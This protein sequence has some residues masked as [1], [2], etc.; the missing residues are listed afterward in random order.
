MISVSP[1][2]TEAGLRTVLAG[3]DGP[4]LLMLG[5]VTAVAPLTTIILARWRKWPIISFLPALMGSIILVAL[6]VAH[7]RHELLRPYFRVATVVAIPFE[8]L[9]V[10][11]ILFTALAT[12]KGLANSPIKNDAHERIHTAVL[13]AAG[14][15]RFSEILAGE[16]STLY[17]GLFSWFAR[18]SAATGQTAVAY[19]RSGGYG[20][21]LP[22]I[23]TLIALETTVFHLIIHGSA[24][25]AAWALTILGI[26]GIIWVIADDRATWLRPILIDQETLFVNSGLRWSG[27]VSL[28]NIR[29]VRCLQDGAGPSCGPEIR[30]LTLYGQPQLCVELKEPVTLERFLGFTATTSNIGISVDDWQSFRG[31]LQSAGVPVEGDLA[32]SPP[33]FYERLRD[34]LRGMLRRPAAADAL[35]RELAL[36]GCAFYFLGIPPSAPGAGG[37]AFTIHRRSNYGAIFVV[38]LGLALLEMTVVHLMLRHSSPIT[39]K[40]MLVVGAYGVI[41]FFGDFQTVRLRPVIVDNESL[42]LRVG[43]R[44]ELRIPRESVEKLEDM[45]STGE[46]RRDPDYARCTAFG[47]PDLIIRLR[48]PAKLERMVGK[49]RTVSF[50]GVKIDDD[51]GFRRMLEATSEAA[52]PAPSNRKQD[53]IE[54][55]T[56]TP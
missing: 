45:P 47:P 32:G 11:W 9:F 21:A 2:S 41:W 36:L 38:L 40:V 20:V 8:S 52:L 33:D 55:V 7:F 28:S 30:R 44:K 29:T 54:V 6:G 16:M 14:R 13:R 26:Y 5:A 34:G 17:Y 18:S 19:R 27:R 56:E 39:A 22:G 37:R 1:A 42:R 48:K 23:V 24:P 15:G 46:N 43:V 35:A 50:I 25:R 31:A 12:V 4:L 53:E 10:L 49:D 51:A 3:R